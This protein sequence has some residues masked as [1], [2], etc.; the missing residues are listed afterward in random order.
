MFARSVVNYD[1]GA[2]TPAA[3]RFTA[4]AIALATMYLTPLLHF[5]PKATLAA[6]IIVAVLSLVDL[7][8]RR[9]TWAI[10]RSDFA[11]MLVTI[12]VTLL[13][14]VETGVVA[15]RCL[16]VS[17]WAPVPHQPAALGHR[18][19]GAGNCATAPRDHLA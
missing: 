16:A 8:A 3:G 19:A 11:A 17:A 6:T 15:G 10:S 9:R 13:V 1:T 12:A 18:W 14:G 5:L 4:A 2:V 7:Q